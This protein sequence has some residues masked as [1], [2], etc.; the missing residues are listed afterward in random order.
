MIPPELNG[1]GT[2]IVTVSGGKD[3]TAMLL[4]ALENLP[5]SALRI[6]HN[7]TG[8]SWPESDWYLSM[9]KEVL[10]VEI[11]FARAGDRPLP[12][13]RDGRPRQPFAHATNLYDMVHLRGMWPSFWQRYCTHYLKEWPIRLFARTVPDSVI[14]LGERRTES[15]RRAD[16]PYAG[17]LFKGQKAYKH[18]VYRPI[19]DWTEHD[20]MAMLARHHL[21]LNSVYNYTDRVGCWCCPLA[22]RSQAVTFCELHP[23]QAKRW[24]E[25]ER[26]INHTYKPNCSIGGDWETLW[27]ASSS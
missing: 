4:W 24:A 9:L 20:V 14:L 1:F 27:A 23:D 2:Y 7:P 13:R 26:T 17:D 12:P 16:L 5:P 11:E 6:V 3:S 22:R 21:P 10:E 18:S 19:L 8:A 15:K 25:L